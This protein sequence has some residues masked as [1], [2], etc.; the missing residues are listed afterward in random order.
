[1]SSTEE[2]SKFYSVYSG[3]DAVSQSDDPQ[4]T[5]VK[6]VRTNDIVVRSGYYLV[7]VSPST[8]VFSV[9]EYFVSSD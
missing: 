1:M 3:T 8:F 6:L 9:R 7:V 5:E 4:E 2:M